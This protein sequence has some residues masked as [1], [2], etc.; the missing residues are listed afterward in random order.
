MIGRATGAGPTPPG[1]RPRAGPMAADAMSSRR[2]P[3]SA[4]SFVGRHGLW[5]D[6]QAEAASAV[7]KATKRHKLDLVRFSFCDQHG[8]LRGKTLVA[9]EAARAIRDGRTLTS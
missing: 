4:S 6:A 9:S 7:D 1:A 5:S 2:Q 8:I 3:A